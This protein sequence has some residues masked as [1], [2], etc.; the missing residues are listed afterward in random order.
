VTPILNI[1]RIRSFGIGEEGDI[2]LDDFMGVRSLCEK[3]GLD[4]DITMI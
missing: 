3:L 2:D 4:M 1:I